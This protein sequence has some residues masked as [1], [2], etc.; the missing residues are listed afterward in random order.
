MIEILAA[1]SRLAAFASAAWIIG[2]T[3]FHAWCVPREF[4]KAPMPGPRALLIAVTVLAVGHAGLMWAQMLTLVPL[5]GTAADW[6]NLVM[7]THFG[8]IW[9]I[10]AGAA[11]LLLVCVLVAM[12][13]PVQRARWACAIAAAL[14]LGLAPWGGHGAGAEAPWQVLPPNIAHMLAVAVWF[15][16]LP[17][18]L[19]TVRAYARNQSSALT[20]SALS[21]AL[22]RFSQLSMALMA[23]I[24][25]TGVWLA[26]LYIENEGDL[27]GTRY[28]GLLVGKVGLL[29]FALLFANRLRTGFLPVLKRAGNHAEPRA[30]SALALRHVAVELGAATGVLLCAVWLAQTT[31]AFHEPEPHWWLPFRWS[32]EATWA[33]PSL[34]VWML[35]ALAALIAAGFAATWRRGAST[36]TS[37]RVTAAVLVVAAISV[38]A[39][40]FAVPA[41]PDTFRRSQVPYLTQSVANGRELFM[42]HCTACHGTGGLGDGPLAATLPVPPANLSEPHTALHT[43]GDMY[44]WLS[45]GIP[46]SGMPGFGAVLSED[47]R[48][49][50]INFMR[51]FSQGFESRVM[52]AGIVPGQAWLGAVNLYIEGASGPTELQG[53]RETH[54]VLLAFLGGPS[55]DARARTLA[56]A[57][58]ELQARRTQVLAVPLDDADLPGD[59][60]YPVLKSGAADAWSAYELLSRTVGDR[61][62]PDRLGMAWTHAEFL[63][64][65]F[66]YVRARWIAEDDA[67]GWSDPAML[68]PHLDRLNAEPRLRPPP[69]AH[70]H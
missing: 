38:L 62:L 47:D 49:D 15:G 50:L 32:F 42:Q 28:G 14:Y 59:L 3:F 20:T 51:T 26:D 41:Y 10:R 27:L 35:G 33:D 13:R 53:Y 30:R 52:R 18:W 31:P 67:V 55:A 61:G 34:R 16:A 6:R 23:V 22:Q 56:M 21:A 48:W 40:A 60:P 65:R 24:V 11:A 63:I 9:L 1:A 68:Y 37:L 2:A 57:H 44:W 45:H 66:G 36:S 70:I 54:N 19:L 46:E 39:W 25:V 5:G 29:A 12:I 17:S 8:Q 64:D 7:G 58:P 69:D 4:I 43:A